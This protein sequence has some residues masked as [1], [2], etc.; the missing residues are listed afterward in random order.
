MDDSSIGLLTNKTR[1][2]NLLAVDV[3]KADGQSEPHRVEAWLGG[4][5]M[6]RLEG[7]TLDGIRDA[8]RNA[9]GMLRLE[10]RAFLTS[11]GEK[12]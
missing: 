9:R 2:G 5:T 8:A 7:L 11:M 3:V 10:A 6:S 4:N 1:Y 12:W